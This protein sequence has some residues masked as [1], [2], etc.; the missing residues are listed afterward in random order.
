MAKVLQFYSNFG[1]KV[2]QIQK[3]KRGELPVAETKAELCQKYSFYHY[4]ISSWIRTNP[5]KFME[6]VK[7]YK[8]WVWLNGKVE[9][10][11]MEWRHPRMPMFYDLYLRVY[12]PH[13]DNPDVFRHYHVFV[14]VKTGHYTA[15]WVEQLKKE[16]HNKTFS[17]LVRGD[18]NLSVLLWI[19]KKS[20]IEVL[21]SE[22]GHHYSTSYLL[23][24][25]LDY[26]EPYIQR[27]LKSLLVEVGF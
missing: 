4:I 14:E 25:E 13:R 26:L 5:E 8:K 6:I 2:L 21:K 23:F 1:K 19:T 7:K 22:L 18:D 11:Q 20:E 12:A 16:Y 24:F 3:A 27:D 15:N 10:V 9:F 17:R